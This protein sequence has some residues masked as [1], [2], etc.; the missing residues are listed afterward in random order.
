MN[1]KLFMMVAELGINVQCRSCM[2]ISILIIAQGKVIL[3][4]LVSMIIIG[5][6]IQDLLRLTIYIQLVILLENARVFLC[7]KVN[8]ISKFHY[9]HTLNF[10]LKF[11]SE[12]GCA[13]TYDP[14]TDTVC[15]RISSYSETYEDAQTKCVSEGGYL[16]Y[17]LDEQVHVGGKY[18]SNSFD[19]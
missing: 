4:L 5:A 17:V 12:N 11:F 3:H 18:Y 2:T 1:E 15:A 6:R 19:A 9:C 14:I 7:Q 8:N 10:A 16:L 13:E